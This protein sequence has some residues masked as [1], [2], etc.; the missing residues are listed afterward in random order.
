MSDCGWLSDRMPAVALGRA[1][2]TRD[3]TRH[4]SDCRSCQREWEL[5]QLSSRLG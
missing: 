3:E 4:L 5:V 2:W 1:E